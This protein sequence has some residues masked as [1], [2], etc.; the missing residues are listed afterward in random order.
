LEINDQFY[1]V[2]DFTSPSGHQ[3]AEKDDAE[4]PAEKT[5]ADIFEAMLDSVALI[6]PRPIIEDNN[7]RLFRTR[8]LMLNFPKA[9]HQTVAPEQAFRVIKDGKDIGFS[10]VSEEVGERQGETG[11]IVAVLSQGT[12]D[13]GLTVKVGSEMFA[14]LDF[15]TSTESWVT[16]NVIERDN[17]ADTVSE[18]GNAR[19]EIGPI[20]VKAAGGPAGGAASGPN[21]RIAE[22]Y[23]MHVV[24]TSKQGA[25]KVDKELPP[26]YIPQA[27]N[28]MLPRLV[29]LRE[30]KTYLFTVWLGS[31]RELIYRYID[32]EDQQRVVFNGREVMAVVV[33]DRIGLEGE[34]TL[35]YFRPEGQYLGSFNTATKVSIV[36]S[37]LQTLTKLW[38]N[39]EIGRPHLLDKFEPTRPQ[40]N[41]VR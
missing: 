2:F 31:E 5:A 41:N 36:V 18:I 13:G 7:N 30:P 34:P 14:S 11:V 38:P 10:Y 17:K 21:I 9:I 19:K 29:P 6:D 25:K 27:I 39:V 33:K 40:A 26:F 35:H 23:E 22:K 20:R 37:D 8:T 15:K 24:Q 16:H 32:V 28:N 12:G 1:Y 3:A 4:D